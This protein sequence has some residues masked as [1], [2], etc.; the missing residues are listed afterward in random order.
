MIVLGVRLKPGQRVPGARDQKRM[1]NVVTL[2]WQESVTDVVEMDRKESFIGMRRLWSA[3][4]PQ[5][6]P[7]SGLAYGGLEHYLNEIVSLTPHQLNGRTSGSSAQMV[8]F[9]LERM[10]GEARYY[11]KGFEVNPSRENA[12]RGFRLCLL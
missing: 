9:V 7:S 6:G 10:T 3:V 2:P 4:E 1:E 12:D 8:P 5:P 11:L